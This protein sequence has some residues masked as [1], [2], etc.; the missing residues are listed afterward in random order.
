M[1]LGDKPGTSNPIIETDGTSGE[2]SI[3]AARIALDGVHGVSPSGSSLVNRYMPDM[4]KPG[5]V[6]TGEVEM[7][8]AM[9]LKA[10]RA[11]GALRK[12]KI[13]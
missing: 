7:V 3:Y 5:A 1:P 9:A 12:I 4:T 11:A 13:S 10:T 8:A 2:T 6:K